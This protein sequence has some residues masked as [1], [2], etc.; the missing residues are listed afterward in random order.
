LPGG[1]PKYIRCYDNGGGDKLFCKKCLLFHD[2]RQLGI[3][4]VPPC[5]TC[6]RPLILQDERGTF[7]RYTVIFSGN[8]RGRN[9]RCNYL[10]MSRKPFHP[11]GM[12]YHAEADRV[13]DAPYGFTPKMGDKSPFGGRRIP[14][15]NLPKDCQKLV[16][17][18]Y[19]EIWQLE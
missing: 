9:R 4:P 13:I 14:F 2:E 7:D 3:E 19:K 12:G 1:E 15:A 6:G 11:Q 10:G 5:P 16:L 17:S 18:D 8:Y